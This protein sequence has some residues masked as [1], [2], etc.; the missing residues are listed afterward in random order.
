M[1]GTARAIAAGDLAARAPD[2]RRDEVGE[3]G[4]AMNQMA[5]QVQRKIDELETAASQ[6]QQLIDNLAHEMRTPLTAI[7]GWAETM[8]RAQMDPEELMEATDTILFESRR[9]LALSQQLLKL[10]VL[11]GEPLELAPVDA[12]DLLH[13]VERTIGPKARARQLT[14]TVL[15]LPNRWSFWPTR[16]CW[17]AC[18]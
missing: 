15:P 3:L 4:R 18:W 13:R 1:T 12:A 14:F 7:G 10:S 9:V 5:G 17:K 11:R 16:C 6:K 8:Q 2:K